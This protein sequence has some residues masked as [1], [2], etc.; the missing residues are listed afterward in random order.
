[1]RMN[2]QLGSG[3]TS[4]IIDVKA[5]VAKIKW[6]VANLYNRPVIPELVV[7]KGV[8]EVHVD[9]IWAIQDLVE[10]P[11]EEKEEKEELSLEKP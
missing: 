1:M 3:Q 5:E 6:M 2:R 10:E 7:T 4:N 11:Q 9:N 8:P